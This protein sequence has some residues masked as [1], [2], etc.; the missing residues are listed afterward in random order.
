M[1][2]KYLWFTDTHLNRVNPL[3]KLLFIHHIIK[4]D[5][6]AVF[7]TG[8][9]SSGLTLYYDLYLL[10]TFIRC[11]I[12]FVLGNHDY[13]YSDFKTIENKIKSL[14]EIFPNLIWLTKSDIIHLN[15]DVALIG[16]EGWYDGYNG[17]NN[18]LKFT[19]DQIAV[20]EFREL[21][22][23]EERLAHWRMLSA[24]SNARIEQKLTKALDQGYKTVYILTH[25][26]PWKEATRDRG[27]IL[28]QFWLPYN[29]NMKLGESIER[30]MR[31]RPRQ[32]AF[33]LSGH[34]HCDSFIHVSP[35]IECKVN[36]NKHFGW[37]RNEEL[38]FI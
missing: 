14:Q 26:P 29:T 9:I 1:K 15:N 2:D 33:V 30:I 6:K 21:K 27:T 3:K 37:M 38:M 16:D 23:I 8:D 17:D 7:F 24:Q 28:E 18:Y 10:A 5:P 22:T 20:K 13:W 32:K 12:Y 31:S 19:L 4:E 34:T 35:N 11:P 36:Q 25:F